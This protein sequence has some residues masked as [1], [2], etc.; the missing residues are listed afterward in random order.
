ML[1]SFGQLASD[2]KTYIYNFELNRQGQLLVNGRDAGP[3]I[4]AF[5]SG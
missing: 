5:I 2:G 1:R 4:A 3:L